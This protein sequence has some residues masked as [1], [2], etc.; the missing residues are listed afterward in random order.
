MGSSFFALFYFFNPYS[1]QP[2]PFSPVNLNV[3]L[4]M[5]FQFALP[6]KIAPLR[7]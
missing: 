6:F 3:M 4:C 7:P 5:A 2:E 1:T